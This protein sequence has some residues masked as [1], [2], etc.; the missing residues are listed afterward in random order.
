[1]NH[2]TPP[3]N[4]TSLNVQDIWLFAKSVHETAAL[5][6]S[7][8]DDLRPAAARMAKDDPRSGFNASGDAL[9]WLAGTSLLD[10]LRSLDEEADNL[11]E[12]IRALAIKAGLPEIYEVEE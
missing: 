12:S 1:M 8:A 11:T 7:L 5:L 10:V 9:N 6:N 4:A 2:A 3:G